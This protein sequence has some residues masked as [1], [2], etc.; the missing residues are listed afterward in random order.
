MKNKNAG[1]KCFIWWCEKG[2]GQQAIKLLKN[3]GNIERDRSS[4]MFFTYTTAR[5]FFRLEGR[6]GCCCGG[7]GGG[8]SAVLTEVSAGVTPRLKTAVAFLVFF[9]FFSF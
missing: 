7:R 4:V 8:R 2:Q 5:S 1:E 6:G 3:N 9:F